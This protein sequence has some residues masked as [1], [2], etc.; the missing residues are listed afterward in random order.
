MADDLNEFI[1]EHQI[2]DP[3]I[4]GHSMG[5]KTAMQFAMNYPEKLSKL[6]VS[7]LRISSSVLGFL[8]A[9]PT[10]TL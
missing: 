2:I 6:V 8:E 7:E 9:P 10:V 5:G 1:E 4:L 3:I